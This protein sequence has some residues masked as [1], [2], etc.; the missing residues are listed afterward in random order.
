MLIG[1]GVYA[2]GVLALAYFQEKFLFFPD[3][4]PMAQCPEIF[5]DQGD[6]VQNDVSRFYFVSSPQRQDWIIYFHGNG[7]RACDRYGFLKELSGLGFNLLLP[8]YP[9]YADSGELPT[10][11]ELLEA[12][13]GAMDALLERSSKD[14]KVIVYGESLGSTVATYVASQRKV[15][16][17]ILQAP[18]PSVVAV[19]ESRYFFL[20]VRW[21]A[22]YSFPAETWAKDVHVPVF[23]YHGTGD[24]IVPV[25]F[26][27]EQIRNFTSKDRI[28]WEIEGAGHLDVVRAAGPELTSRL[29][30][31]LSSL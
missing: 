12:S 23:A 14:A 16:G 19:A 24:W 10:E 4:T 8:E 20:P 17:L 5:A 30:N 22:K 21:L 3:S 31:F 29:R 26:G 2:G 25:Q 28:F 7:G 6:L 18:F 1:L 9:G 15:S 13:L 27:R 11:A